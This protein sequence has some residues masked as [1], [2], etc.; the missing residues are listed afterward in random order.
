MCNWKPYGNLNVTYFEKFFIFSYFG[1]LL[2]FNEKK[3]LNS[4]PLRSYVV[5]SV[6]SLQNR[7]NSTYDPCFAR[8]M[9]E[10]KY[11]CNL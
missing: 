6:N 2:N 11:I 7:M 5:L 10:F 8:C 1:F 3:Y 4:I 9:Y